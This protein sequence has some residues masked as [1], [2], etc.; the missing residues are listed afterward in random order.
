MDFVW[1]VAMLLASFAIQVV[2]TPRPE[3]PKPAS[4]DDFNFPQVEDGT[5]QSVVFGDVWIS[6]WHVLWY[7]NLRT[8]A[9]KSKGG[10]K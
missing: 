5:P 2:M 6:D 9:I 4:L 3:R 8:S 7:G 1:A 10:K